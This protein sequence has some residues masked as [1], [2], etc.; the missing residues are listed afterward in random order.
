MYLCKQDIL[1]EE[2]KLGRR[3]NSLRRFFNNLQKRRHSAHRKRPFKG[4]GKLVPEIPCT[5]GNKQ[6]HITDEL[7]NRAGTFSQGIYIARN[8]K[9]EQVAGEIFLSLAE[10]Q[11]Y[12]LKKQ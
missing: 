2:E 10:G 1:A 6:Y 12:L 4:G 5:I 9:N 11:L 3:R 7:S 8:E